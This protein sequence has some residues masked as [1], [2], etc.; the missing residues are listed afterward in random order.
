MLET[1]LCPPH[2]LSQPSTLELYHQPLPYP[3]F[4]SGGQERTEE[5]MGQ[6]QEPRFLAAVTSSALDQISSRGSIQ[7]LNS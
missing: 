5:V 7:V 1:E 2:M 6:D 4:V 3:I